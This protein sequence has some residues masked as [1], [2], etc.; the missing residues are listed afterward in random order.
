M[1]V[2]PFGT[3]AP[4]AVALVVAGAAAA[5][6]GCLVGGGAGAWLLVVAGAT[7]P[8]SL[9]WLAGGPGRMPRGFGVALAL[10]LGCGLGALLV[11]S[12]GAAGGILWWGLPPR[13]WAVL[14]GLGL[15]PLV[16]VSS[17]YAAWFDRGGR[18]G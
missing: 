3:G 9:M 12:L 7:L 10:L 1:P 2:E 5:L 16:L 14:V 18:G 4:A 11:P 8:S 13:A 15:V 17:A 6:V